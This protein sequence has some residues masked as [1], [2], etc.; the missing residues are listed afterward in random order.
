MNSVNLKNTFIELDYTC[1]IDEFGHL[2]TRKPN[3]IKTISTF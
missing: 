1:L 3:F 2:I